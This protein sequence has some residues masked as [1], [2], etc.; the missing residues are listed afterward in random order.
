MLSQVTEVRHGRNF[1]R[2]GDLVRVKPSRSGKH[3]GFLARFCYAATDRGGLYYGLH[4][5]DSRG[6][7]MAQRSIKP[8]RVNRLATTNRKFR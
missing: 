4:E 2:K 7:Y 5:L 8:E 6:R 1:I 3:D